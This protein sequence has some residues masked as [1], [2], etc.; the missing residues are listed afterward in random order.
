[1]IIKQKNQNA[2][3]VIVLNTHAHANVNKILEYEADN[4]RTGEIRKYIKQTIEE[5]VG[6]A[7][8]AAIIWPEKSEDIP[9]KESRFLTVYMPM[10]FLEKSPEE[11][12]QTAINLLTYCGAEPRHYRNG[13]GLAMP[14]PREIE[15]IRRAARYLLAV[16]RVRNR[17]T[18]YK[19]NKEQMGQL[20]ER[21]DT[22]KARL[23][24][25]LRSLY[26]SVLLLRVEEGK[27]ALEKLEIGG[28]PL[29]AQGM[30]ERVLELLIDIHGKLYK[31]VRASKILALM[32]IGNGQGERQA[33]E[34]VLIL[35]TFFSNPGFLRI[36]QASVLVEAIVQGI[37]DGTIAY[38]MKNRLR[39]DSGKF[40][41]SSKNSIF[42]RQVVLDEIDLDNGII[43]LPEYVTPDEIEH[44]PGTPPPGG[45]QPPVVGF[46]NRGPE[47]STSLP[48]R[49]GEP[50]E[51]VTIEMTLTK[52]MIFKTFKVLGLLADRSGE[53]K[54]KVTV[55]G[56]SLSGVD[57]TWIHNA[58]SGPLSEANI[59]VFFSLDFKKTSH[60]N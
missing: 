25:G 9:D 7:S 17:S 24:S 43:L 18:S 39:K 30:H 13:L 31:T 16:D 22:V 5:R 55:Q 14:E 42:N 28:R 59:P 53:N 41:V 35:D 40:L 12:T 23:E 58:I 46:L 54:I 34:T 37:A 51:S 15:G 11:R 27:P 44:Q 32:K 60:Q 33:V 36:T 45:P 56:N 47:L 21:E 20:K 38:A 4:V 8:N 49:P 52:A 50:V 1:M 48:P 19:L 26:T 57:P 6:A 3:R 10:E 29:K 2:L